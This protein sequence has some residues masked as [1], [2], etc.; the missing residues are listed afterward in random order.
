VF[1]HLQPYKKTSI[2][3]AH[4]QKLAPKFYGP[5]TNLKCLG[6]VAYKLALPNHFKLHPIFHVSFLNKVIG[7][8]FQTQTSL[9]LDK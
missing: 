8:T 9:E 7:T 1:L 6:S 5:Y 4:C 2:K 3:V